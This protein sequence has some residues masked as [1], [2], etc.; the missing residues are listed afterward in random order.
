MDE[1][2]PKKPPRPAA[3]IIAATPVNHRFKDAFAR[4][5]SQSNGTPTTVE[6]ADTPHLSASCVPATGSR[7]RFR[8]SLPETPSGRRRSRLGDILAPNVDT[9]PSSSPLLHRAFGAMDPDEFTIPESELKQTSTARR[10]LTHIANGSIF[11]TPTRVRI[12]EVAPRGSV[13]KR[14]QAKVGLGGEE[15]KQGSIYTRLGWDD[16]DELGF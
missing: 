14:F 1:L 11:E 3:T 2:G 5:K 9:V 12:K 15:Q 4:S 13:R 7:E 16:D 8:N 6:P 10:P